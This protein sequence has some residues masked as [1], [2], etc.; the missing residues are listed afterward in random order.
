M[1]SQPIIK[2]LLTNDT[3][4]LKNNSFSLYKVVS[5]I[6]S[7]QIYHCIFY[8]GILAQLMLMLVGVSNAFPKIW[9]DRMNKRKNLEIFL[10]C[11]I[12][13][14]YC[15]TPNSRTT[16][17]QPQLQLGLTWKWLCEPPNTTQPVPRNLWLSSLRRRQELL[18]SARERVQNALRHF[19]QTKPDSMLLRSYV[20]SWAEVLGSFPTKWQLCCGLPS[21]QA[22]LRPHRT[23]QQV[24]R[25]PCSK[26]RLL[27]RFRLICG[28]VDPEKKARVTPILAG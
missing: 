13:L 22:C 20:V 27:R 2:Q 7:N 17:P 3:C 12:T 4:Y 18:W 24:R 11:V 21:I 9:E 14:W 5:L 16:Q 26:G 15:Q 8:T 23:L 28:C 19:T 1:T 25:G 10:L 6:S